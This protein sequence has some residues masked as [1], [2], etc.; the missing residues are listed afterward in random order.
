MNCIRNRW[1]WAGALVSTIAW[2]LALTAAYAGLSGTLETGKQIPYIVSGVMAWL[3]PLGLVYGHRWDAGDPIVWDNVAL[4]HGR[5]PQPR[6][7]T[8]RTLRRTFLTG[9]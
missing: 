5:P 7:D 9:P 1:D 6:P 3:F 4:Q 2:V 8:P